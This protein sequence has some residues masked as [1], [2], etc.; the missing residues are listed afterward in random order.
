VDEARFARLAASDD[1]V[2]HWAARLAAIRQD[3]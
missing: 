2:A 1:R 3:R